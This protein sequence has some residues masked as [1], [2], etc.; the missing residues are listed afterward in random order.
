MKLIEKNGAQHRINFIA[1]FSSLG[2]FLWDFAV[3]VLFS[4]FPA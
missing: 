1:G 3:R 4:K 2:K